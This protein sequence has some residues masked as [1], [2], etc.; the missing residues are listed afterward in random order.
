MGEECGG[1][2]IY[3]ICSLSGW[4]DGAF[5]NRNR[6]NTDGRD[7]DVKLMESILDYLD[8]WEERICRR[9]RY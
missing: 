5:F 4:K 6:R 7:V 8:Y 3:D 1:S 2:H 9:L